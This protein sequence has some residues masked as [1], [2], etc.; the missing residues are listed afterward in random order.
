MKKAGLL[1]PS[2]YGNSAELIRDL[3][4][5][6][7]S[8]IF[9]RG[10]VRALKLFHEMARRVPAYKDFLRKQKIDPANIKTIADFVKVPA[11]DKQNYLRSYP[12]EKLCWDGD[13]KGPSWVIASTSGSTG[14]PFYFPREKSQDMQYA[15]TAELYLRTNFEIHKKSTLYID[16]FPLG[17]WIG[18]IFTYEVIRT[19]AQK[20]YSL[21]IITTG[22]NKKEI[23]NAVKNFG[24]HF[25]QIIIACYAPFL[26]DALDDGVRQGVRWKKYDLKFIFSAEGFSET[27]R[28]YIAHT[29]GLKNVYLDT[30][31][32]YGTV[33]QGT[34]AYETPL[35]ILIRR[36]AVKREALY[37]KI[38]PVK[39]KLPTLCQY[40]PELFFFEEVSQGLLCSSYSGLPLVRYDLKDRGGVIRYD[41]MTR[42]IADAGIDI[43]REGV[44]AGIKKTVWALPFVY[45]YERSDMSVSL[46]AFLVYPET[47]RKALQEKQFQRVVTGKFTMITRYDKN[48]DQYLEINVELKGGE[49]GSGKLK[50][51]VRKAVII[52][53]LRENSE[54]WKTYHEIGPRIY[55][56][57]V[58]WPYEDPAYFK[59]G[60]KHKWVMKNK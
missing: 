36:M 47:I 26:K 53:L 18:G 17:P 46:Y 37:E 3:A 2:K 38:F 55:P 45:V 31:N 14:E 28:D 1:I 39:H 23:I 59:P 13:F 22:V 51:S 9:R 6:S 4:L 12:L 54:F 35:S 15:G 57:I 24:G 44:A 41:D 32:H 20:G 60:G 48:H 34:L 50:D 27:F 58:F 33:D 52:W 8:G 5:Q 56:R 30:L 21:S 43:H 25:D 10:E 19:I 29:A 11:I 49:K 40:D 7:G 42:R 16:A